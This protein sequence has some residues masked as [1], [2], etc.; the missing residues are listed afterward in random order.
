ML[1]PS[2]FSA[3]VCDDI[4]CRTG[5]D[6]ENIQSRTDTNV[7]KTRHSIQIRAAKYTCEQIYVCPV[8]STF[9]EV[10]LYASLSFGMKT[11]TFKNTDCWLNMSCHWQLQSKNT[12]TGICLEKPM[13]KPGLDPV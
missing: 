11:V 7:N 1:P 8:R 9:Q 4:M 13:S 12:D 5:I 6:V 2:A 3:V 10:T